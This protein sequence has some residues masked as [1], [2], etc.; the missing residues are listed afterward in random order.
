MNPR[1]TIILLV[2][3]FAGLIGLWW[4]DYARIPTC[5]L[6]EFGRPRHRTFREDTRRVHL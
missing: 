3:F 6:R 2:L 5:M 1:T 4:A